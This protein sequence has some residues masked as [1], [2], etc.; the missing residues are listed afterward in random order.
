MGEVA[1]RREESETDNARVG[2]AWYRGCIPTEL[3]HPRDGAINTT[4]LVQELF[5]LEDNLEIEEMKFE[6]RGSGD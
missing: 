1:K 5:P 4:L 3:I 2:H 6:L